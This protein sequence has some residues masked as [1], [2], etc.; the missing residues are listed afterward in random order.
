MKLSTVSANKAALAGFATGCVLAG[1][2]FALNL[3]PEITTVFIPGHPNTFVDPLYP[4]GRWLA[5]TSEGQKLVAE[6]G[7]AD[8]RIP[9]GFTKV[10]VAIELENPDTFEMSIG[11]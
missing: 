9:P 1:I 5:P 8:I 3:R 4:A 6:P 7:Y 10:R 11:F 2:F